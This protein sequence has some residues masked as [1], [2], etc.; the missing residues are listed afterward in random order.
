[1]PKKYAIWFSEIYQSI[2]ILS[3]SI[4]SFLIEMYGSMNLCVYIDPVHRLTK[5]CKSFICLCHSMSLF[6]FAY[7]IAS[8]FGSID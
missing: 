6:L 5:M 7:G 2:L 1:M 3:F 4:D 8:P